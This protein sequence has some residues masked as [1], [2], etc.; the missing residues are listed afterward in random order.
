MPP[1]AS[2]AASVGTQALTPTA[3]VDALRAIF[4]GVATAS[5]LLVAAGV[6]LTPA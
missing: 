5:N 3:G 6:G 1:A 2:L 4:E